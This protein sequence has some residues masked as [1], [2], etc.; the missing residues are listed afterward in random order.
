MN[1]KETICDCLKKNM[2]RIQA[3]RE[4]ELVRWR[5]WNMR[6]GV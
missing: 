2:P 5:E 6:G 3:E 1:L 4:E